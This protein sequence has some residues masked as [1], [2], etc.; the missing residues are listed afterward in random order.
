M[1]WEVLWDM[2]QVNE[3]EAVTVTDR[4]IKWYDWQTG[5]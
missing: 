3:K 1:V 5:S 2:F 4:R